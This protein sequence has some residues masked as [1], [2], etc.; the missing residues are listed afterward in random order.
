MIDKLCDKIGNLLYDM[1]PD[2]ITRNDAVRKDLNT[3]EPAGNISEILRAFYV[4]KLSICALVVVIG[5]VLSAMLWIGNV[6]DSN[7][8]DNTLTRN[9]YGEGENSYLLTVSDGEAKYDISLNLSEREYTDEELEK[10]SRE[11]LEILDDKI[12]GKNE[13]LDRIEYDMDFVSK[14]SPYPFSIKYETDE[15]FILNDGSLVNGELS[16][17]QIVEIDMTLKY[18]KFEVTHIAYVMVYSKAVKQTVEEMIVEQLNSNESKNRENKEI[19][20][21]DKIG[22]ISLSWNYKRSYT[23][24]ICLIATPI[25]MMAIFIFKDKDLH[26][27]VEEREEEMRLDYPEIVS[28]LALLIGAGMTV[29]NAWKKI[30][31]DYRKSK[32]ESGISRYAYEEMLFTIY[33]MDS[34]ITQSVA[35]ERFGRRC[36]IPCYNKLATIVSQNIKK[37]AVDLPKLL[38]EEARE[39]FEDRKH[40][41]RKQGEQA[42]T[43]LLGPM[44]LLLVITMVIIMVP[45]V[46]MYF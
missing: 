43:K 32:Q 25:I 36:R 27:K 17:P 33:E 38:K 37:G 7:I 23:G 31:Y 12:L 9:E 2:K 6:N 5:I 14:V 45:A 20:L 18:E 35:Y 30:A 11:L 3:L 1:L 41:A 34:G 44:M 19:V 8:V 29:P 40:L 15:N 4:K 46:R 39:A 28:S 16:T 21:P 22:D 10:L 13:S 24:L 26:K 42:G